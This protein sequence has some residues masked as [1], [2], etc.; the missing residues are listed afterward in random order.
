MLC[1][2]F[3]RIA[4]R[5][6]LAMSLYKPFEPDG[7]PPY[8]SPSVDASRPSTDEC[9][10]PAVAAGQSLVTIPVSI[11]LA[12]VPPGVQVEVTVRLV[13]G[14][15]ASSAQSSCTASSSS[16]I[17]WPGPVRPPPSRD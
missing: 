7:A 6:S 11:D 10:K 5:G 4:S 13:V 17:Q 9:S 1:I 16:G 8:W 2:F 15:L 3:F 14:S 12:K